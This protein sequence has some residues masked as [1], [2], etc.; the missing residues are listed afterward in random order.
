MLQE[1][2]GSPYYG[3]LLPGPASPANC[4][5][6]A[7]A[8]GPDA[9][10][11]PQLLAQSSPLLQTCFQLGT[12]DAHGNLITIA[13]SFANVSAT[14]PAQ[15]AVDVR[16]QQDADGEAAG[17]NE[18]HSIPVQHQCLHQALPH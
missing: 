11:Q 17:L 5:V 8:C 13:D 18:Q 15:V 7:S 16:Q 12:A 2:L 6:T 10:V 9:V 3:Q 1:L 4:T 14:A